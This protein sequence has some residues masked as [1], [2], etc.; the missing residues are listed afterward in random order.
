MEGYVQTAGNPRNPLLLGPLDGDL[1]PANH[2][3]Q[4]SRWRHKNPAM[5]SNN[6]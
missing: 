1:L 3:P 2:G 6:E 5:G 4:P